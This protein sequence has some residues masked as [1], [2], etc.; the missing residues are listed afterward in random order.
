MAHQ[1]L[2]GSSGGESQE[3]CAVIKLFR[4]LASVFMARRVMFYVLER[5]VS[6]FGYDFIPRGCSKLVKVRCEWRLKLNASK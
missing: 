2:I 1:K 6:L 3:L 4:A 5:V